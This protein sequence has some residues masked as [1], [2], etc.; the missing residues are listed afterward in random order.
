MPPAAPDPATPPVPDVPAVAMPPADAPPFDEPPLL[1][2]PEPGP[3]SS[4][5]LLTP[6]EEVPPHAIANA[7]QQRN[8]QAFMKRQPYETLARTSR[9]RNPWGVA[10]RA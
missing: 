7:A 5:V 10:R 3:P 8:I 2:P 1:A 9:R 6:S 4:E